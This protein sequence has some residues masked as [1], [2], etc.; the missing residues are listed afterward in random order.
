MHI[1][2]III[3]PYYCDGASTKEKGTGTILASFS[4]MEDIEDLLRIELYSSIS[5]DPASV[6]TV[7]RTVLEC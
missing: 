3:E 4:Y 6:T 2:R 7:L 5:S 1:S